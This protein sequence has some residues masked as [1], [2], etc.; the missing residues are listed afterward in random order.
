MCMSRSTQQII[1]KGLSINGMHFCM[2]LVGSLVSALDTCIPC[3]SSFW[4]I[5]TESTC[6]LHRWVKQVQ[7]SKFDNYVDWL[8]M[9]YAFSLV[10]VPAISIPCGM[11]TDGRPVGLQ[12][13]GRPQQ[14]AALLAA[15]AA[16]EKAH[17]FANM[18]PIQPVVKHGQ[19]H[20]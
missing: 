8:M 3:H 1:C 14:D 4:S 7:E 11:T 5:G 9:T 13:V 12:I 20:S 18:V 15:A 10:D 19:V 16:F 6:A 2:L 17:P